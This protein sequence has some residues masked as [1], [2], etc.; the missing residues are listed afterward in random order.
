[1]NVNMI[2]K[3]L[4]CAFDRKEHTESHLKNF[5]KGV[6]SALTP[7]SHGYIPDFEI[8]EFSLFH[9]FQV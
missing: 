1:M 5:G 3:T 9:Y 7:S 6:S 2:Q 4:E 8:E